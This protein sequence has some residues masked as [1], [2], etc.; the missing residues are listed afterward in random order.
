MNKDCWIY[1]RDLG[2]SEDLLA[3]LA[4][5][6][7]PPVSPDVRIPSLPLPDEA[8]VGHW[9]R[10][11]IDSGGQEAFAMLRSQLIELH[12]PIQKGLSKDPSYRAARQNGDLSGAT[13]GL[14]L[15]RP[16]Q[17]GIEFITTAA[18]CIPVVLTATR[19]DFIALVC[20]ILHHNEPYEVPNNMGAVMISGYFNWARLRAWR[21]QARLDRL[22]S[23]EAEKRLRHHLAS[24][25]HDYQ[26]RF[27]ILSPGFY[28]GLSPEQA[29]FESDSWLKYSHIIRR[30]HE[31]TH[32]LTRRVLGM[33]RTHLLDELLADFVG[34]TAAF[35]GRFDADLFLALMGIRPDASLLEHGRIHIYR[36]PLSWDALEVVARLLILASRSLADM[37]ALTPLRTSLAR[38]QV[39]IGLYRLGMDEIA[40][41]AASDLI[42]DR[43]ISY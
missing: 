26:D 18:G 11:Q 14:I 43:D 42:Q 24:Y 30:E 29:G 20:A 31:G 4:A 7:A 28:S 34:L 32:Y 27:I 17:L 16:D 22:T 3:Q 8:F 6:L 38:G 25:K 9:R 23:Q 41:R 15:E 21:V 2:C 36:G 35:N 33:M 39:A 1:L 5:Y 40:F 13:I 37:T 12:F 19:A 10:C